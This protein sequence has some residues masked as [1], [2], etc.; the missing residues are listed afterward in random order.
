MLKL[1]HGNKAEKNQLLVKWIESG[2]SLQACESTLT[3]ER[4]QEGELE[5]GTELLT[6]REMV[7]KNFSQF[8]GDFW[9]NKEFA[10][11]HGF[12]SSDF[13]RRSS[14]TLHPEAW[15]FRKKIDAI[16][17]KGDSVPDPDAPEDAESIRFWCF[18]SG[19]YTDRERVKVTGSAKIGC[20]CCGMWLDVKLSQFL[21][22]SFA[23]ACSAA[24]HALVIPWYR[25][26]SINSMNISGICRFD[27]GLIRP[28]FKHH[29]DP[30]RFKHPS[31]WNFFCWRMF[32]SPRGAVENF[33]SHWE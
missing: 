26:S 31:R 15:N 27:H 33:W 2:E 21:S 32:F 13:F 14:A 7:E 19:R 12:W 6:I 23:P 28:Q 9:G 30:I 4:S 1:W 20:N 3:L 11:T 22:I 10:S 17:R 24:L 16:L 5:K 25:S 29:Y 18:T 8:L